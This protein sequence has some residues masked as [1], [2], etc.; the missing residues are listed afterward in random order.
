VIVSVTLKVPAEEKV[1]ETGLP[2]TIG[3]PSP[4]FHDEDMFPVEVS[5][6]V[7]GMFTITMNINTDFIVNNVCL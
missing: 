7:M 1:C 4:K 5:V 2:V 6:N 3:V